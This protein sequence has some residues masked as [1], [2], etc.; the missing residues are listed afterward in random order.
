MEGKYTMRKIKLAK[1][2]LTLC[3]C[4]DVGNEN[5]FEKN[6]GHIPCSVYTL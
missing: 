5:G 3:S 6:T 1:N 4:D 2:E